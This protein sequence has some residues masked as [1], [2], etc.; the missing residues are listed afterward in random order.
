M[1]TARISI[2]SC[3]TPHR[4][5]NNSEFFLSLL[6]GKRIQQIHEREEIKYS[7]EEKDIE[8]SESDEEIAKR[9]VAERRDKIVKR[10]SVERQIPASSQ[11]KEISREIVEIKRK[12]LI[13]DKKAMH[14][15]EILMQLPADNIVKSAVVPEQVIKMKMG[16]M[17]STEV[18]KSDFDKELSHKF[19]ASGRSSE[20]EEDS[21]SLQK[22]LSDE[23]VDNAKIVKDISSVE[24][25]GKLID[26]LKSA[27]PSMESGT[28]QL[29]EDFLAVEQYSQLPAHT[30]TTVVPK[31]R[32]GDTRE[33]QVFETAQGIVSETVESASKKVESIISAFEAPKA[34]NGYAAAEPTKRP[35]P[36]SFHEASTHLQDSLMTDARH[37]G[38]SLKS[39]T[40]TKVDDT[41]TFI[42]G[43]SANVKD[44]I[45][46]FAEPKLDSASEGFSKFEDKLAAAKQDLKSDTAHMQ[47]QL[48]S[49][50][51]RLG[52]LF[53][54][55]TESA[56]ADVKSKTKE[57]EVRFA[58]TE[59]YIVTET[60]TV[61]ETIKSFSEPKVST[62]KM[63]EKLDDAKGALKTE[64]NKVFETIKT[65][66]ES[67]DKAGAA[68]ESQLEKEKIVASDK[69]DEKIADFEAKKVTY[70]FHGLEPKVRTTKT[71]METQ[72]TKVPEA[73]PR[74]SM[75]AVEQTFDDS[76]S[77]L[78]EM[79][80][81]VTDARKLTQDFLA[82]EQESQLPAPR[83]GLKEETNTIVKTTIETIT[84]PA[85]VESAANENDLITKTIETVQLEKPTHDESKHD[86][87]KTT[88]QMGGDGIEIAAPVT[89]PEMT[90]TAIKTLTQ[91]FLNFEQAGPA[92]TTAKSSTVEL[93]H[94]V[95]IEARKSL[96]DA[97]FCKSVQETITKKMSEGLI[98]ISEEL[99]LKGM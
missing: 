33:K 46:A 72:E 52:K 54:D 61:A 36:E 14:E 57:M 59:D 10:L 25:P 58:D 83:S 62:S 74:K 87:S 9:S 30:T 71:E 34:E 76:L 78:Q 95:P 8:E 24:M 90:M 3:H 39:Y 40:E 45:K 47:T 99:K 43:E 55:V 69:I 84:F 48:Q 94:P 17:D 56:T 53:D 18:S 49:E 13:E 44:K 11:K 68:A 82:M 19:K 29:T 88:P 91:D 6:L 35:S 22:P 50:S 96:T 23:E 77:K 65:L 41:K 21:S 63:E 70:E 66:S 15:S 31:P 1:S 32:V 80:S 86:E 42:A 51:A 28:K 60:K 2:V 64:S 97:E 5:N 92:Y 38:D 93:I 73:A 81:I 67:F 89:K 16:K 4:A 27:M 7:A 75:P 85:V 98:E 12:S 26:S 20:E 79:Q 37:M